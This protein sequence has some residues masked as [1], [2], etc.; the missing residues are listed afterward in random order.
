M[1]NNGE[2]MVKIDLVNPEVSRH[3]VG[4]AVS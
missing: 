3:D 1:H 4:Q 2:N